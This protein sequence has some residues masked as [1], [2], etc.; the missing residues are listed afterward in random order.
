MTKLEKLLQK[1]KFLYHYFE[2]KDTT[3]ISKLSTVQ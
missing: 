3:L 2:N 1:C